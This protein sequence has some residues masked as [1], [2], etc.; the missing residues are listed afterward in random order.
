MEDE[1]GL[2]SIEADLVIWGAMECADKVVAEGEV[3]L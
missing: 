3:D 1:K 2:S